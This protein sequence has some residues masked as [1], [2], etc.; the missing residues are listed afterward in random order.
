MKRLARPLLIAVAVL[1]PLAGAWGIENDEAEIRRL[2]DYQARQTLGVRLLDGI[3][4]AL[5]ELLWLDRLTVSSGQVIIEGRAYNTNAIADFIENLD[6]LP[7]FSEPTLRN[8]TEEKEEDGGRIYRFVLSLESYPAARPGPAPEQ[9][10][11]VDLARQDDLP[12]VVRELRSLLERPE[13]RIERFMPGSLVKGGR[14]QVLP[15]EISIRADSYQVLA[16]FF[17]RLARSSPVV[18]L[19]RLEASRNETGKG[20]L[21]AGFILE[22][23]VLE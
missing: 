3:S 6:K 12:R 10:E 18:A 13:I 23:P 7:G 19:K 1:I 16:L 20:F 17:D 22:I 4:R 5:P 11:S 8:T 2:Q 14:E 9:T 21:A 15:V